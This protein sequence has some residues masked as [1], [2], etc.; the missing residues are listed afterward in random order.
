[1]MLFITVVKRIRADEESEDDH[2]N[3][4]SE[5]LYNVNTK[6]GQTTHKQW[7]HGAVNSAGQRGPNT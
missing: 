2:P 1:M 5:V 4:K 7:Q 3:F 6:Q